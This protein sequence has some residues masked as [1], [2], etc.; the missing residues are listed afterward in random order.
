[1]TPAPSSPSTFTDPHNHEHLLSTPQHSSVHKQEHNASKRLHLSPKSRRPPTPA[2]QLSHEYFSS[3]MS[4]PL[5]SAC[6]MCH[7]RPTTTSDLSAYLDCET[8]HERTCF[9]CMRVC[10]GP[11][12]RSN[13]SQGLLPGIENITGKNVCGKCSVEVGVDGRVWCSQCY[14]DD[15]NPDNSRIGP[16]KKELQVE[17]VGRIA[18]WLD[19]CATDA[20]FEC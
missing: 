14:E 13:N 12:C 4:K 18:A 6:H 15:E 5:T 10:E 20:P 3:S 7:R 16:S 11:L 8:C 9:V 2:S 19:L 17:N 1:M